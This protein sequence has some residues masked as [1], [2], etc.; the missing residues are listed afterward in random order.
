VPDA[1]CTAPASDQPAAGGKG[2]AGGEGAAG[3]KAA[4][5]G[6]AAVGGEAAVIKEPSASEQA[7]WFAQLPT[8]FA[9]AAALFTDP[10]GR[11]LLVKPNYRD[12]WSL[13][14]GILEHGEPPHVGCRREVAEELGID[15]EPGPLLVVGWVGPDGTRPK[16]IVHF[17]FDGGVLTDDIPIRLQASEL[18]DYRFV[19]AG[20]LARYLPPVISARVAA[21]LRSRGTGATVYL[22]WA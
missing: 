17:V 14:G 22:P 12:H 10:A 5:S 21:A 18:D 2:A 13:A 7:A 9:A 6:E 11:V 1:A 15:I 3:G 8:M 19:D 4:V 16:P 20:D